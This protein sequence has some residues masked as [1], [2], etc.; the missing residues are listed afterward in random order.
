MIKKKIYRILMLTAI[1]IMAVSGCKK[2]GKITGNRIYYTDSEGVSL[3]GKG[4]KIKGKTQKE[5]I[6]EILNT[7]QKNTDNIDYRSPFVK[8][9]KV[10]KWSLKNGTLTL[11]FNRA[12]Q[13]MSA[14][15]EI[16]LRAAVVQSVGQVSGVN[17]VLFT[18][19]GESL[20]DQNGQEIGYMQPS[21]FVQNTGTSLHSYQNETFL[22]YYGNKQGDRLVKEK[23]NIRYN[24][25]I[26][27]EKILVEQLIK[28]PSSDDETAVIPPET[29]VLSVSVKDHVCYVNLDEGFL[30]TTSVMNPEVPV[31]AI[32]NSIIE[33]SAIS[34]VQILIDGKSNINYMGKVNLEKPLSRNLNIVEGE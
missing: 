3:V 33:G 34:R 32:V 31:Y 5:Q 21:D 1:C 15:E 24:S 30:D 18:I 13:K 7:I 2:E 9:V 22:L 12:Y 29:K 28:G 20:E 27:R 16:V 17:S 23:V 6:E 14:T 25:S 8:G 4:V 26:S 19:N 10:K 11:D